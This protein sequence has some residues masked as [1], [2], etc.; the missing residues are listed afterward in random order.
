[1][2]GF[3]RGA[4]G[5]ERLGLAVSVFLDATIV[6]TILVPSTMRLLGDRNW[7]LPSWLE[8]LPDLR[9]EREPV[10]VPVEAAASVPARG[11]TA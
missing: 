5:Q 11:G 4:G 1:M 3:G 10:R 6:R 8:W 9:V 7:Y 2:R